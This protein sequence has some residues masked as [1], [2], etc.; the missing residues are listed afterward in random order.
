MLAVMS[1]F[2]LTLTA[3][4]VSR[5][6][7]CRSRGR[8]RAPP[9]H[10]GVQQGRFAH[11]LRTD[12]HAAQSA[13]TRRPAL[14]TLPPAVLQLTLPDQQTIEYR[15]HADRIE[16]LVR[17]GDTLQHRESYRVVPVVPQG[18]TDG[19]DRCATAGHRLPA[20][21]ARQPARAFR[22]DV[23][24]WRVDAA[25]GLVNSENIKPTAESVP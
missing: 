6:T 12:A 19:H 11:Q 9:V 17:N 13:V 7:G 5:S 4:I 14:V 18:W 25:L 22:A 21:T 23:P 8:L 1:V 20:T 2:S 10:S 15:L 3:I 24:P 16:R